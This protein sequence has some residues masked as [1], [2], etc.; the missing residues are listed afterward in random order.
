M[1]EQS[2]RGR[3]KRMDAALDNDRPKQRIPLKNVG[4]LGFPAEVERDPNMHYCW[5]ID[6]EKGNIKRHLDAYYEFALDRSGQR[7]ERSTKGNDYNHVLMM[8]EKSYYEEDRAIENK[9]AADRVRTR[10][11]LKHGEYL[12]PGAKDEITRST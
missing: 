6:D 7:V 11:P 9:K 10:A 3:K 4:T 5:P 1:D 12:P 2:K 8:I